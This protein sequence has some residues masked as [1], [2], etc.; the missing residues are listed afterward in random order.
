MLAIFV[1][2]KLHVRFITTRPAGSP[3]EAGVEET[4]GLQKYHDNARK[5]NAK[6]FEDCYPPMELSSGYGG[7]GHGSYGSTDEPESGD[8]E[9][10]E[11]PGRE[12][13]RGCVP[14]NE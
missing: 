4:T 12:A 6:V 5:C 1:L 13:N 11:I 2:I 3:A 14:N 8:G 10:G 9:E 7:P